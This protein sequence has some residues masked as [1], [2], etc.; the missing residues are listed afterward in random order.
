[1]RQLA[2]PIF[3][4]LTAC[5]GDDGDTIVQGSKDDQARSDISDLSDKII[6]HSQYLTEAQS[7]ISANQG[8]INSLEDDI[9]SLSADIKD[10]SDAISVLNQSSPILIYD[11]SDLAIGRLVQLFTDTLSLA[12][13]ESG[14]I[15]ITSTG[16]L[17]EI[18]FFSSPNYWQAQST[19]YETPDCTGNPLVISP[20]I[21]SAM[22]N[23]GGVF[24]DTYLPDKRLVYIPR[25]QALRQ[26]VQI[27]SYKA[28]NT[29]NCTST[30]MQRDVF[31]LYINDP[32]V[33]G[34]TT[35]GTAPHYIK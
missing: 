16:Y 6:E 22:R 15:G 29:G 17:F 10:N 26:D 4:L 33:T 3:I 13:S 8:S 35:L 25:K 2:L 19:Y 28:P 7:N 9:S 5:G 27:L 20:S 1:M 31:E 32:E 12:S 34:I 11:S 24:Y 18:D 14:G 21:S 23:L 30:P